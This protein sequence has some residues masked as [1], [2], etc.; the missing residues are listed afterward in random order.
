M[1]LPIRPLT[2]AD[3]SRVME[4]QAATFAC[5]PSPRWYFGSTAEEF[6]DTIA[7]GMAFGAFDGDVPAGFCIFHRDRGYAAEAG[8][9]PERCLSFADVMVRPEYRRRGL[10][11][12][13]LALAEDCA[14][15]R[16][17]GY[18]I[19]TADPDNEPSRASFRKAGYRELP[20]REMYDGRPRL[21]LVKE[22][23][24]GKSN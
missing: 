21:V 23:P 9:P 4:V 18:I 8:L 10:H 1:E 14:A 11:T 17:L 15:R 2:E 13:F 24:A 19:A 20:Q 5:L 7:E 22:L 12:R 16:G 3:V 6:A